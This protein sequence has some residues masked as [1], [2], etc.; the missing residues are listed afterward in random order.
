MVEYKVPSQLYL[1]TY[2]AFIPYHQVNG[3]THGR[4]KKEIHTAS[5]P[6]EGEAIAAYLTLK[7]F[8][9]ITTVTLNKAS[10]R[11]KKSNLLT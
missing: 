4:V 11:E 10:K 9:S 2:A 3:I 7:S 5:A 6:R 8:G 1:G